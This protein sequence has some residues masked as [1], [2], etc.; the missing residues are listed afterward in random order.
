M[1]RHNAEALGIDVQAEDEALAEGWNFPASWYTNPGNYGFEI[2]TI[3]TCSWQY[4]AGRSSL[5]RSGD[6]ILGQVGN[7]PVVIVC[8]EDRELHGFINACRHRGHPVVREDGNRKV[9][10]CGYHGWTYN[11]NG[12][13]KRAPGGEYE[14]TFD[15]KALSLMPVA[16]DSWGEA[17][18]ANL[19]I[20]TPSYT[21]VY[22]EFESCALEKG[23]DKEF[24]G[25]TF[26]R[27]DTYEVNANWKIFYDNDI[28]CYHC[29]TIHRTSFNAAYN[30]KPGE[31]E[32][33]ESAS[34][35]VTGYRFKPKAK[36]DEDQQETM[37]RSENNRS[38]R[39]FP[40]FAI[41]Q[42]DEIAMITQIIPTGVEACR[43][44]IDYYVEKDADPGRV[45]RWL[46]MWDQTFHED[47]E[48]CELIQQAVRTGGEKRNR[49]MSSREPGV[50]WV[51]DR[52]WRSLKGNLT[53]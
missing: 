34:G 45:K 21:A 51:R 40:G 38:I 22:P 29:P 28:E 49:V 44:V 25:F 46:V 7:V 36:T 11:L 43:F 53:A 2:D 24:D 10:T 30:T 19:D 32:Y 6:I 5:S 16:V 50:I 23:I 42:Q 14:P 52:I 20:N 3:F 13:L 17:V 27:R 33:Y 37:L 9:L 35:D 4:V 26:D 15:F 48:V 41:A 47:V 18:F 31:F 1:A 12:T 39:T 8:D